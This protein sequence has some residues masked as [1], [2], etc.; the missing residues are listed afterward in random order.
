MFQ[1]NKEF[2]LTLKKYKIEISTVHALLA[3]AIDDP[4]YTVYL[5]NGYRPF[6]VVNTIKKELSVV[7]LSDEYEHSENMYWT[8][9]S[10]FLKITSS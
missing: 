6:L 3:T 7:I 8:E 2:L 5:Q 10:D 1:T 9:V 4:K